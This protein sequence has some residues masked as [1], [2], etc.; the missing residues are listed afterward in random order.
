MFQISV[1]V[2]VKAGICAAAGMQL[3]SKRLGEKTLLRKGGRR[4]GEEEGKTGP[5]R[6]LKK[7]KQQSINNLVFNMH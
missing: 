1:D 7:K 3:P 5:H 6:L 4:S 2:K